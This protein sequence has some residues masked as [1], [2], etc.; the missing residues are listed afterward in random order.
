MQSIYCLN[1]PTIHI[2]ALD[3][4]ADYGTQAIEAITEVIS[5]S[6]I[7]E[8]VRT[9]GW[10]QIWLH[11]LLYYFLQYS[12]T[13]EFNNILWQIQSRPNPDSFSCKFGSYV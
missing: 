5:S 10:M 6:G 1:K 13:M 12:A 3:M 2:K 8:K 7:D 4:L 11:L 9:F